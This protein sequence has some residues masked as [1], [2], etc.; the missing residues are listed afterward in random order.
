MQ[1]M[2][3]NF[4]LGFIAFRRRT[5]IEKMRPPNEATAHK[6]LASFYPPTMSNNAGTGG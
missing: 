2:K 5:R 6:A 1:R 4:W 3:T